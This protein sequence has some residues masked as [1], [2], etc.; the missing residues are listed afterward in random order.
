MILNWYWN[1]SWI[2]F[3][4]FECLCLKHTR[5]HAWLLSG[6]NWSSKGL[7]RLSEGKGGRAARWEA[8]TLGFWKAE[9]G[10]S[11]VLDLVIWHVFASTPSKYHLVVSPVLVFSFHV[12]IWEC[13]WV[14]PIL[15]YKCFVSGGGS[16]H[17]AVKPSVRWALVSCLGAV[18]RFESRM[19][20]FGPVAS[21][22]I[23][24]LTWSL[25][26]LPASAYLEVS[27]WIKYQVLQSEV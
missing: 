19:I 18:W 27:F 11:G 15:I 6:E 10:S 4:L 21:S 14:C 9:A 17:S 24:I 12:R 16:I 7:P 25:V 22:A 26:S 8:D 13:D 3:E 1:P 5:L 23:H 20:R 2:V